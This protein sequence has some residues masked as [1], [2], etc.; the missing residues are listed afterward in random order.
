M[1]IH[2]C[3]ICGEEMYGAWLVIN[4]NIDAVHSTINVAKLIPLKGKVEV[5]ERCYD[6]L[7]VLL[8]LYN[9]IEVNIY[10]NVARQRLKKQMNGGR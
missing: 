7:N 2:K 4:T 3:D 10:K 9:V 8:Y 6:Q 5:C 1:I